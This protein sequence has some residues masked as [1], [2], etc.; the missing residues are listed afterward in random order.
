MSHR[1]AALLLYGLFALGSLV[2]C[3]RLGISIRLVSNS[4]ILAPALAVSALSAAVVVGLS[5][6]F[7]RSFEWAMRLQEEFRAI[8]GSLPA[9]DIWILAVASSV[10]E[11]LLFRGL[12][13]PVTGVALQGLV[14]GLLHVGPGRHFLPWTVWAI[15]MGWAFGA[16]ALWSGGLAAPILAHFLIN[17]VN[18]RHI[19][20]WQ[21]PQSISAALGHAKQ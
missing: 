14:F 8:V 9:R 7:V 3:W 5:R 10:G 1:S 13:L 17:Y 11:E 2:L 18:L 6:Y 16:L 21:R 19:R 20:Q 4:A 15:L 12:L